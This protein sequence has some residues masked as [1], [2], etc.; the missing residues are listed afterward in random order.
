M[1]L[2]VSEGRVKERSQLKATYLLE[3]RVVVACVWGILPASIRDLA[4]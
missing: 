1:T 4:L 3:I 2:A